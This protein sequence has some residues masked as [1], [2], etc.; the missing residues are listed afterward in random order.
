MQRLS[1]EPYPAGARQLLGYEDVFRIRVGRCRI[2]YS[3]SE[4]SVIVIILK[5][6]HRK[7][8]YR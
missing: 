6:G 7:D 3:V 5:V 1:N 8:V 2:L 4:A